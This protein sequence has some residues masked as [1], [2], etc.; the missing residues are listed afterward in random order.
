VKAWRKLK[1]R[2]RGEQCSRHRAGEIVG[3]GPKNGSGGG[4]KVKKKKP[5]I[6]Q[7]QTSA[8]GENHE[9][10]GEVRS[11]HTVVATNR[12]KGDGSGGCMKQKEAL[13]GE[14]GQ[15]GIPFWKNQRG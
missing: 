15:K 8:K 14:R 2:I 10:M 4:K 7:A 9:T 3:T 11:G 1:R 5:I 6:K 12:A 13:S